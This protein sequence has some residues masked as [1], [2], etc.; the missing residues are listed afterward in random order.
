MKS[1]IEV[2]RKGD[3]P[4]FVI[5]LWDMSKAKLSARGHDIRS[6]ALSKRFTRHF[7]EGSVEH[8]QSG[9]SAMFH[10]IGEL[11]TFIEKHRI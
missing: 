10:S 5:R 9:D 7:W 2:K 4:K 11:L 8:A 1:T 6:N 3:M